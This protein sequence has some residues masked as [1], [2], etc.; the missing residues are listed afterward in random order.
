[1]PDGFWTSALVAL[2]AVLSSALT[3]AVTVRVSRK[4][5]ESAERVAAIREEGETARTQASLESTRAAKSY[6][7]KREAYRPTV[8]FVRELTSWVNHPD[9]APCPFATQNLSAR[10]ALSTEIEISADHD[11]RVAYRRLSM[12][13]HVLED[14]HVDGTAIDTDTAHRFRSRR[15][16]FLAFLREDLR[17]EKLRGLDRARETPE[18]KPTSD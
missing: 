17:Q 2:T 12:V 14:S 1:M 18:A 11:T 4:N 16:K 10:V 3:A 9:D 15:D 13:I 5:A 7:E 8:Q 6:D